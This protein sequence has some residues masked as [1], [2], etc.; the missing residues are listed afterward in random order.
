MPAPRRIFPSIA[1]ALVAVFVMAAGALSARAETLVVTVQDIRNSDGE[2]HISLYNSA[3][4]FLVDGQMAATQS[5][6]ARKGEVRF[7][8]ANLKPGTYA[9]AAYHDENRS[10]EFDTNF[11]GIPREGYG[12]SNG[13]KASLGPPDFEEASVPLERYTA[14]TRLQLT[15]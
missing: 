5:R 12:F 4:D 14:K 2:I 1:L 13:A 10:G 9:A 7:V 3:D 6:S 8:F 11:I 15:Y